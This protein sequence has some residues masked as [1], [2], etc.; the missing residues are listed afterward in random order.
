MGGNHD[1]IDAVILGGINDL[2]ERVAAGNEITDLGKV[3]DA[4]MAK[5]FQEHLRMIDRCF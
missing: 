4:F 5:L 1:Q 3:L 2:L